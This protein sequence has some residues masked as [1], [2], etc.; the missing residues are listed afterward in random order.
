[1]VTV[2]TLTAPGATTIT[3]EIQNKNP[4]AMLLLTVLS[5]RSIL[6][7]IHPFLPYAHKGIVEK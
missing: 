1:M 5:K 7:T 6:T 4:T 3:V 2:G